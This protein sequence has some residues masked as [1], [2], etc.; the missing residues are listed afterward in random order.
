VL[1]E[2]IE[3]AP[4]GVEQVDLGG[5]RVE[6]AVYG[7][8]G[9]L[10]ALPELRALA[11]GAAV[12]IST[13]EIADDW[14]ERW[15]QF[16]KPVLVAAPERSPGTV[17]SIRV[18]PPWE[19]AMGDRDQS[20]ETIELVVDPGRAFG[21]GGHA[22]TRLCLGLLLELYAAHG[23]GHAVLDVGTGSGVLAIAA[24]RLGFAPVLG[25]DNEHESARAAEEN[26]AVNAAA[27]QTARFD[28]RRDELPWL[29]AKAGGG[30]AQASAPSSE[31]MAQ[32]TGSA[33]MPGATV[34]L[35]NLLRPLLI[36][37]SGALRTAPAAL[38]AGG[39]L[40]GELDEVAREYAERHGTS[41]RMRRTE[42]AWG[43]L[44]LEGAGD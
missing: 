28:L 15:K 31:G 27:I 5:G 11:G 6:Y 17:P 37:L 26:A 12:E 19:P 2:L 33:P 8:P 24:A 41:E 22:T 7:P 3:L 30:D 25:L 20:R 4:A 23:A 34:V 39:L 1:A 43:A 29:G 21:T 38:I 16:H 40:T 18:R 36:E 35:A 10:P 9:E 13:T 32:T 42:G 14:Q 44:W